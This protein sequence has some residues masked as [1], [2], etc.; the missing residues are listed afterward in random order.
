M[1]TGGIFRKVRWTYFFSGLYDRKANTPRKIIRNIETTV[2][3]MKRITR[4]FQIQALRYGM[5]TFQSREKR[6]LSQAKGAS[7]FPEMPSM[8]VYDSTVGTASSDGNGRVYF[9]ETIVFPLETTVRTAPHSQVA[10]R[11]LGSN[12][13]GSPGTNLHMLASSSCVNRNEAP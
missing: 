2:V 10:L 5:E 9:E 6:S 12:A 11:P 1:V 13:S 3:T 8:V 7:I 4:K